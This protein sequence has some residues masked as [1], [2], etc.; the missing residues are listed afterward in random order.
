[1]RAFWGDKGAL[2]LTMVVTTDTGGE[3]PGSPEGALLLGEALDQF[4][5]CSANSLQFRYP[6]LANTQVQRA[7]IRCPT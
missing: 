6:Y 3:E 7:F 2:R 4:P 5:I 1:M